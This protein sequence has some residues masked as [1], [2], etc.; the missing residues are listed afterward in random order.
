MLLAGLLKA[1]FALAEAVAFFASLFSR[2]TSLQQVSYAFSVA[3]PSALLQLLNSLCRLSLPGAVS[4]AGSIGPRAPARLGENMLCQH[5]H[6]A[7][8]IFITIQYKTLQYNT[9]Q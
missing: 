8:M 9:I 7:N 6:A 2:A 5:A 4:R 1:Y 3:I